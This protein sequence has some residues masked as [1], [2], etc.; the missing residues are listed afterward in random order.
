MV[1]DAFVFNYACVQMNKAGLTSYEAIFGSITFSLFIP[2]ELVF[3]VLAPSVA[4][5]ESERRRL[6]GYHYY[7][8][9]YYYYCYH[10]YYYYYYYPWTQTHASLWPPSRFSGS[11][12]QHTVAT[13][14][15]W[16][17]LRRKFGAPW[18]NALRA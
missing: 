15:V 7:Y 4:G 9:Y 16:H 3:F 14:L 18:A 17:K 13:I 11:C 1:R 5:V 2:D 12:K 6:S 10:Y 8:C